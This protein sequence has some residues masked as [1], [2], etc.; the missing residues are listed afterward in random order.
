M[1]NDPAADTTSLVMRFKALIECA[2]LTWEAFS[3][4]CGVMSC[5]SA[6]RAMWMRCKMLLAVYLPQS[7]RLK[8]RHIER[9]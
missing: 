5:A 2:G 9:M 8:I 7:G 3:Y 6:F 1:A 4:L